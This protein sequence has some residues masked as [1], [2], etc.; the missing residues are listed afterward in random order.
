MIHPLLL[1][2]QEVKLTIERVVIE[3]VLEEEFERKEKVAWHT[4][5]RH[6]FQM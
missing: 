3:K 5:D 6:P 4:R 2:A 1:W